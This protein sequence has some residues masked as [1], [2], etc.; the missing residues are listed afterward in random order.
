M[1]CLKDWA[2]KELA[3]TLVSRVSIPRRPCT[4][5][6]LTDHPGTF[7]AKEKHTRE[8]AEFSGG[9]DI[10]KGYVRILGKDAQEDVAVQQP[11]SDL[12]LLRSF[13][14]LIEAERSRNSFQDKRIKEVEQLYAQLEDRVSSLEAIVPALRYETSRQTELEYMENHYSMDGNPRCNY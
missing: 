6:F 10:L 7:P 8:R 4:P 13:I 5:R 1:G 2:G 12:D 14:D 9:H 11:N 3:S